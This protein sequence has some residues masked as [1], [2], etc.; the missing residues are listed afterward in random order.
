M[1]ELLEVRM[2]RL[3]SP[4][5]MAT[6]LLA[7]TL[8]M[9]T[10]FAQPAAPSPAAPTARGPAEPPAE[11]GRQRMQEGQRSSRIVGT[12]VYNDRDERIGTVDDLIVG[13]DGRISEAVLS[14]GGFLGLGAKLVAVP[15]DQLRFE[16]PEP[17]GADRIADGSTL[18]GTPAVPDPRAEA[19]WRT[20]PSA[21][22]AAPVGPAPQTGGGPGTA[23]SVARPTAS[24]RLMLPGAT[25]DT[26]KS[27]PEFTYKD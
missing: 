4:G 10:A 17:R 18:A 20:D 12:T 8:T 2:L 27:L 11:A 26:L 7:T 22:A 3:C 14:V 25:Q 9:P 13:Q 21:S 24:A 1:M 23:P 5:A 6:A 15:Y 16:Q 19:R